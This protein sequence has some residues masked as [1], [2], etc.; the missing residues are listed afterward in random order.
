MPLPPRL[1]EAIPFGLRVALRRAP[2]VLRWAV[3]RAPAVTA[4]DLEAWHLQSAR[5]SPLRRQGTAYPPEQQAAKEHNVAR[6]AKLLDG[7]RLPPGASFSWHAQIGPPLRANGFVPGP[8]LHAGR[9]AMGG[10]GGA[11]QVANM[12][13][14]LAAEAGMELTERHRHGLDLFPDDG[15][16]VPFGCGATVFYPHRDLRFR[17]PLDQALCLR[18]EAR[19]GELR[20]EAWLERDPG[21]RVELVE[22]EHRYTR[23]GDEIWR[24]NTLYRRFLRADAPVRELPLVRN[25]GRVL[26][27]V[28]P[29]ALENPP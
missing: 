13:F 22:R 27:P 5:R 1:R 26:Y 28:S 29:E 9:F 11:C 25:R 24:E 6:V 12:L 14:Q 2:H 21:F 4:P 18:F 16:D 20:G 19:G 8:E 3:R 23:Q 17:N 7:L 15:R 10:G